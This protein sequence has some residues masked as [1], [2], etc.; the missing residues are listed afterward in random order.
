[1]I[2]HV[3][4]HG[5]AHH[6]RGGRITAADWHGRLVGGRCGGPA[7]AA[8]AVALATIA[9]ALAQAPAARPPVDAARALEAARLA[10]EALPLAERVD[11]QDGLVWTGDYSGSLDGTFGRM[12]FEAIAAFQT[13]H[14]FASDGILTAPARKL[15]GE[16]ATKKKTAFGFQAVDDKATGVR[17][18]LPTKLLGP[19]QKGPKGSGWV[20]RDGRV[21]VDTWA[22]TE[23]DLPGFFERMKADVPGR[24]VVYAVLR[25]DWFVISEETGG[26]RRYARFVRGPEGIRGF[27]FT[28]DA[29]LA[30][31]LDRVVIATAG[32][33]EPFPGTATGIAAATPGTAA[34]GAP[35][36]PATAPAAPI[37]VAPGASGLAVTADKVITASA[38]V[39]GCR[40][41][42]VGGRPATVA[43]AD[44]GG[45]ATLAVAGGKGGA[46]RLGSTSGAASVLAVGESGGRAAIVAVP[47]ETAGARLR[48]VLQRGGQGAPVF[49]AGGG[50]LGLVVGR[51][52]EARAI[53]GLIPPADYALAATPA[54]EAAVIAAGGVIAPPT[55]G[56]ATTTGR[57]VAE[58]AGRI[59]A[60]DCRR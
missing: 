36:A 40:T 55:G 30:A 33:F 10:Y 50:L 22:S 19:A 46:V 41:L 54:I 21:R 26:L 53:A 56:A 27:F 57:L 52:D 60:I 2:R 6:G 49:D 48:A 25:A 35:T 17:I 44:G 59:V 34:P 9:P 24:K 11:I 29:S 16:T 51:P 42:T 1:M 38:A 32:R 58:W 31:E 39:A 14:R 5:S 45:I 7:L 12:T 4:R 18:H 15:L 20:S 28:I 37:P 8:L 43:F 13:R 3:P 47:G 23:T